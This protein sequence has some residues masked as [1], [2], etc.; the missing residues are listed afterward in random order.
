MFVDFLL[1]TMLS[2]MA[3]KEIETL[4]TVFF[5]L[6]FFSGFNSY[7]QN[8]RTSFNDFHTAWFSASAS[9]LEQITCFVNRSV[10]TDEK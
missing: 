3:D 7:L 4:K 9:A 5:F 2:D 6:R 1:L 10:P 8:K